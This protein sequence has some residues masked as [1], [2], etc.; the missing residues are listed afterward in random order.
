ML[1]FWQDEDGQ[2]LLEYILILAFLVLTSAAVLIGLGG[3]IGSLWSIA[4]DR[5]AAA[6]E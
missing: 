5:L 2:D 1:K 6:N 4:N 3:G